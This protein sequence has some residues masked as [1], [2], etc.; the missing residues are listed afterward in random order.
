VRERIAPASPKLAQ[1]FLRARA[2]M[3]SRLGTP[4]PHRS[5]AWVW[6]VPAALLAIYFAWRAIVANDSWIPALIFVGVALFIAVAPLLRKREVETVEIDDARVVR[7]D[8]TIREEIAWKDIDEIRIFTT[9]EGPFVEDVFF[10]LV[11]NDGKGCLIPHDA[12]AR[13]QLLDELHARFAGLD[14]AAVISAM[15]STSDGSFLIWKRAE[16]HA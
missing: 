8:G 3:K 11:G 13:V 4:L 1:R 2:S 12:A 16:P 15:G 7:V 9:S 6:W 14:D 5:I 10:A